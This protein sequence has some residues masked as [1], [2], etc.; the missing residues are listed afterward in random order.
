MS[1]ELENAE[2][3]ENEGAE[4]EINTEKKFSQAEV[5]KIV[6]ERLAKEQRKLKDLEDSFTGYKESTESELTKYKE[7]FEKELAKRKKE[8]PESIKTLLEKLDPI[9]QMEWLSNSENLVM[10][11]PKKKIPTTPVGDDNGKEPTKDKLPLRF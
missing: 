10:I 2:L 6:K 3:E 9:E 5:N 4:P 8:L 1:E 11:A 7:T